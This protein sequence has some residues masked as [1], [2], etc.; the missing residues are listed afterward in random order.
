MICKQLSAYVFEN[1]LALKYNQCLL[2]GHLH[3]L[4]F[5]LVTV[6]Q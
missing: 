5:A 3:Y 4:L 6:T 1:T 2:G